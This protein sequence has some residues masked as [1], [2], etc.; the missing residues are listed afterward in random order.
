MGP[1]WKKRRENLAA[2]GAAPR[3]S[4]LGILAARCLDA[5]LF[6]QLLAFA[7]RPGVPC[8]VLQIR[9]LPLRWHPHRAS[10]GVLCAVKLATLYGEGTIAGNL[11]HARVRML[12][13]ISGQSLTWTPA[14][15]KSRLAEYAGSTAREHRRYHGLRSLVWGDQGL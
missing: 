13:L 15:V 8:G 10:D 11:R 6:S 1:P 12:C 2:A 7:S 5:M 9:A 4:I 3:V 14:G